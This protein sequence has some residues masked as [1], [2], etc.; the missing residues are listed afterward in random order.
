MCSAVFLQFYFSIFAVKICGVQIRRVRMTWPNGAGVQTR[1]VRMIWPGTK[2]VKS[3]FYLLNTWC[4]NSADAHDLTLCSAVFLQYYFEISEIK[5]RGT[6]NRRVRMIWSNSSG[7]Q[8]WWVH[9]TKRIFGWFL[10]AWNIWCSN[11]AGAHDL[12]WC[13]S[14]VLT[15]FSYLY[16]VLT[17]IDSVF[18]ILFSNI[19]FQYLR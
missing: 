19:I 14:S 10:F 8:N 4:S 7:A 13:F 15:I 9:S 12:T 11:S 1:R 2:H 16:E 18:T 3:V 6:Q 5:I 17:W